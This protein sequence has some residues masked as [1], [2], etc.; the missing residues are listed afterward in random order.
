MAIIYDSSAADYLMKTRFETI[1]Q[2]VILKQESVAVAKLP[3]RK[4]K[5]TG[6]YTEGPVE[7]WQSRSVDARP[8]LGVLPTP[9]VGSGASWR[10]I[11]ERLYGTMALGNEAMEAC[12]D[13]EGAFV[14]LIS[15]EFK[16]VGREMKRAYSHAFYGN[17]EKVV[18]AIESQE[19]A[20]IGGTHDGV[21][22]LKWPDLACNGAAT[23]N[24][25][26]T[27]ETNRNTDAGLGAARRFL[28]NDKVIG[29]TRA[30]LALNNIA[31]WVAEVSVVDRTNGRITLRDGTITAGPP[32]AND[33]LVLG[34][35]AHD[36]HGFNHGLMGLVSIFNPLVTDTFEG[37]SAGTYP[38][39]RP[40][41]DGKAGVPTDLTVVD[42]IRFFHNQ[43]DYCDE[44]GDLKI[45]DPYLELRLFGALEPTIR[46]MAEKSKKMYAGFS[47]VK[48][49][50]PIGPVDFI[51]DPECHYGTI[52]SL[53]TKFLK[54]GYLRKP[55]WDTTGGARIKWHPDGGD[56]MY[57]FMRMYGN[58]ITTS[59]RHQAMK[60]D[61]ASAGYLG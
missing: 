7:F 57:A 18:A 31:C 59:R 56:G 17:N 39:W 25:Y 49:M 24:F 28:T 45:M 16:G 61:N 34:A 20:P 21:Y 43:K 52:F 46:T 5:M 15:R 51:V 48:V 41:I 9:G 23:G 10:A 55:S 42:L 8:E 19:T 54:I 33:L 6:R 2:E 47:E 60:V 35:D 4:G 36:K 11:R 22:N 13:N 1:M 53:N 58:F 32:V 3:E 44:V 50:T 12:G 29:G 38:D 40:L 37:L 14:R 27:A 30:E 26:S